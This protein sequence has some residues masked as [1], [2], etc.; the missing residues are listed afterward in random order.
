MPYLTPKLVSNPALESSRSG[1]FRHWRNH[2]LLS[3]MGKTGAASLLGSLLNAGATKVL[4]VYAGPVAVAM[5]ATLQQTRQA[6]LVIATG[7]GQ[8]ALVQG[9]SRLA[10]P[11]R[12]AYVRTV[13]SIFLGLTLLALALLAVGRRFAGQGGQLTLTGISSASLIS[14]AA[15]VF[16]SSVFVFQSALLNVL[17]GAG[18]LASVQALASLATL[19]S[20]V[21]VIMLLPS[22]GP[23]GMTPAPLLV[24]M[25]LAGAASCAIAAA[26]L[27]PHKRT[28]GE[29]FSREETVWSFSAARHFFSIAGAM[30]VSGVL[31]SLVLLLVRGRITASQ[32]LTVTG[33][34]DAAWNISMNQ[35]ALVLASMQTHYLPEV[36]RAPSGADGAAQRRR[37]ISET[38]KTGSL[39]AA[40]VIAAV[41]CMKPWILQ[42]LYAAAFRPAAGFL[43]WT[44]L[45]DYLKVS[46][47]ILSI[48]LLAMGDLQSFLLAD[49]AAYGAFL[50]A[51]FWLTASVGA[52]TGASVG[53]VV[54]YLAHLICC[55][56]FLYWKHQFM[57]H[58]SAV[59]SWLVGMG[60][61]LAGSA[62]TWRLA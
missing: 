45:G 62:L 6:A 24:I 7:N 37:Q 54:M 22:Q 5:W 56:F 57:P 42:I 59:R 26:A 4:A 29:W 9:A 44:L 13:A 38:L 49:L 36:A 25:T 60:L 50:V 61:V 58:A 55:A 51:S 43:R 1:L 14:L 52:A 30:W 35:A 34:F 19:L 12:G 20:T 18:S 3:A 15:P 41:A 10:G 53:F 8:T 46:S 23:G 48:P 33:Q 27:F 21:L 11:C 31:A 16:L 2:A 28:I 39:V 47:W 32:G 40:L 17:Q